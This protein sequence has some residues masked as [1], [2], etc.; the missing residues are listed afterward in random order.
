[1]NDDKSLTSKVG[2]GRLAGSF[3]SETY[4]GAAQ[5]ES[6]FEAVAELAKQFAVQTDEAFSAINRETLH[7]YRRVRWSAL[8]LKGSELNTITGGLLHYGDGAV[9]GPQ[10]D[11]LRYAYGVA[12]TTFFIYPAPNNLKRCSYL[13]TRINESG[14]CWT[15]GV[16][17]VLD[18]VRHVFIFREDPLLDPSVSVT[19]QDDDHLSALWI[20]DGFFD[21]N[22][23]Y[24]QYGFVHGFASNQDSEQQRSGL[25]PV[26]ESIVTG[27]NTQDFC[28][29]L[30]AGTGVPLV[31][32]DSV[33]R[34]LGS[35]VRGDF[36]ATDD[37]I[38]RIPAGSATTYKVGDTI[39]ANSFITNDVLL[40]QFSQPSVPSWFRALGLSPGIIAVGVADGLMLFNDD[41]ELVVDHTVTPPRVS[42][43]VGGTDQEAKAFFDDVQARFVAAGRSF[44]EALQSE[45]GANP[46]TINPLE[47]FV[48]HWFRGSLLVVRL[49]NAALRNAAKAHLQFIR[50]LKPPHTLLVILVDLQP[51]K[52]KFTIGSD[53]IGRFLGTTPNSG[54]V[55]TPADRV[56][57]RYVA[58][59]CE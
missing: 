54:L 11:G 52:Q 46:L 40:Q 51:P 13:T 33:V 38:Y 49:T 41:V 32:T 15:L 23:T 30:A 25:L 24:N 8:P 9:Y 4:E 3:W 21:F 16:D 34:V 56:S 5:T 27:T 10:P 37:A 26:A 35:D 53:R 50:K 12:N 6:L 7:P 59:N 29:L 36:L 48:K 44:W 45:Y 31:P 20:C 19:L 2:I 47:F 55:Q 14:R 42:F 1:M 57:I 17:V 28:K 43:D 58:T 22:D 18:P 39:P